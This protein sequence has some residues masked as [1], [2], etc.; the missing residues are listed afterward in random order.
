MALQIESIFKRGER[1]DVD[2]ISIN[3]CKHVATM[4]KSTLNIGGDTLIRW[5]KNPLISGSCSEHH[6][7]SA[8]MQGELFKGPD[9]IYKHIHQPEFV[10][11]AH[12][13]E[14]TCGVQSYAEG[15]FLE[16]LEHL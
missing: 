8:A 5:A 14:E 10:G 11:K 2:D 6:H 9:V 13:D 15:L 7:L 3:S 1:V 12:Q 4:A 16:L